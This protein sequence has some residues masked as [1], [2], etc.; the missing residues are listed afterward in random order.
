MIEELSIAS[1]TLHAIVRNPQQSIVHCAGAERVCNSEV[2]RLMSSLAAGVLDRA[3]TASSILLL[4]ATA[5]ADEPAGTRQ[6]ELCAAATAVVLGANVW[7]AMQLLQ[8]NM[9]ATTVF[10]VW[11]ADRLEPVSLICCPAT[12]SEDVLRPWC[13]M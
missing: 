7:N 12:G 3:V 6:A 1:L 10:Q 9:R 4:E 13:V 5:P 2:V 8:H 11:P